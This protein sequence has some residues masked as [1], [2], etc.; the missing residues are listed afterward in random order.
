MEI[1]LQKSI[2]NS[3][4][5]M[6]NT[7]Y[8]ATYRKSHDPAWLKWRRSL[9][10]RRQKLRKAGISE[11]SINHLYP[12]LSANRVKTYAVSCIGVGIKY[13]TAKSIRSALR[14]AREK[15]YS[16]NGAKVIDNIPP[17]KP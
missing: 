1:M 6:N 8:S 2:W 10:D 11:E 17:S 3:I 15:G 4:F 14:M 7:K 5:Y 9:S 16:C 12:S 13:F